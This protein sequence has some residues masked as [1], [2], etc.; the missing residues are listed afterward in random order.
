MEF[1]LG[2]LVAF[3]IVAAIYYRGRRRYVSRTNEK[4]AVK[5]GTL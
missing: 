3:G 2:V 1:L 5:V 4:E